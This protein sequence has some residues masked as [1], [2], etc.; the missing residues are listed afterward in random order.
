MSHWMGWIAG[1]GAL[2][3]GLAVM[4]PDDALKSWRDEALGQ[5]AKALA[6]SALD[7]A[8]DLDLTDID[9]TQ[10]AAAVGLAPPMLA[11]WQQTQTLRLHF[12]PTYADGVRPVHVVRSC[13]APGGT[14]TLTAAARPMTC[15][16][17]STETRCYFIDFASEPVHWYAAVTLQLVPPPKGQGHAWVSASASTLALVPYA[18]TLSGLLQTAELGRKLARLDGLSLADGL[19]QVPAAEDLDADADGKADGW[20][21]EFAAAGLGQLRQEVG[22]AP[23][24]PKP[25]LVATWRVGGGHCPIDAVAQALEDRSAA[26]GALCEASVGEGEGIRWAADLDPRGRPRVNFR[27]GDQPSGCVDKAVRRFKLPTGGAVC[28]LELVLGR[29]EG[30]G[31]R[32]WRWVAGRLR[33]GRPALVAAS[34]GKSLI[35]KVKPS[36]SR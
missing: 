36:V 3:G 28:H 14:C 34:A 1:A 8:L 15:G 29:G 17:A 7:E 6:P 9:L 10:P 32:P 13:E 20:R 16:A 27:G 19:R 33:G 18:D 21:F 30:S 5:P 23:A 12:G 26:L 2:A 22:P 25:D 35:L 31:D 4:S 11:R 24:G